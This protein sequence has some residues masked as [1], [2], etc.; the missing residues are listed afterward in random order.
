MGNSTHRKPVLAMYVCSS[1]KR[2]TILHFFVFVFILR[3]SFAE[4]EGGR[5]RRGR[6]SIDALLRKGLCI[7]ITRDKIISIRYPHK[8]LGHVRE[9]WKRLFFWLL[10]FFLR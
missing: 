1:R 10:N 2:V 3:F 8:Y 6:S 9:K 7:T 5:Q 4:E